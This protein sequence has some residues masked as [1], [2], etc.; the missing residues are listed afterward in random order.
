MSPHNHTPLPFRLDLGDGRRY[1]RP[2]QASE[3]ADYDSKFLQTELWHKRSYKPY[4]K[5]HY[6]K[7]EMERWLTGEPMFFL[8]TDT[9]EPSGVVCLWSLP[10]ESTGWP[11]T[12]TTTARKTGS[13][14]KDAQVAQVAFIVDPN[15]W[16]TS[17][18]REI[19]HKF[20]WWAFSQH[21][22]LTKLVGYCHYW[23]ED[24]ASM[25]NQ[26]GF[27]RAG[28]GDYQRLTYRYEK[29]RWCQEDL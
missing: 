27:V 9:N 10:D 20:T 19:L 2:L 24:A 14:I 21:P 12:D 11:P 1:V 29:P 26:E 17:D 28:Y 4:Y 6:T 8:C 25:W 3:T 5:F 22:G 7:D 15:I 18:L 16:D 23:D 13:D